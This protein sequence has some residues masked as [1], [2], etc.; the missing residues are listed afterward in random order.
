MLI[1]I[2]QGTTGTTCLALSDDL[3]PLARAYR[4]LPNRFP[5][6]G[7][8]EQEPE[9][10]LAT[11]VE[12][13]AEVLQV[14]GGEE[15]RAAGL[16]NQGETVVAWDRSTGEALGPAIVW[17]DRRSSTVVDALERAGKGQ[18]ISELSGL[19]LDAYFS[20]SKLSWLLRH[21]RRVQAAREAGSL[22]LG[23]LDAW[24]GWR[25]AGRTH[26][27]DHSTASRTQLLG[28]GG[29]DWDDELLDHFGVPREALPSVRTSLGARGELEHPSWGRPL[30]WTASLV[31]QPAALAGNACFAEGETKVTY[32]TGCFALANA[33]G[34]P[35]TPPAGL[36]PITAWSE[37]DDRVYAVEGGAFTAGTAINWLIQVGLL[38]APGETAD[39]A[40]SV[41]DAGDV[42]FLPALSGLGAPWWQQEAAGAFAG[43]SSG[44]TRAHL[45]RAV[46]DSIALRVRDILEAA[47][48]AGIRKPVA[49]LRVDGGLTSNRYL[50][51]RQADLLGL[52]LL[53][54]PNRE[55][56]AL[57]AAAMAGIAAGLFGRDEVREA[58]AAPVRIE[59]RSSARER[60]AEYYEWLDW[61]ERAC[62]LTE[63]TARVEER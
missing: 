39:L 43:L 50:M 2:D 11:V 60:D 29:D 18:A 54:S 5:R 15:V 25:L 38:A 33:G 32:G 3:T 26:L 19:R 30:P 4:D 45:V 48:S 62:Q 51:Q 31:D 12:T 63:R 58:V 36:L 34:T 20:A 53:L 57:G 17:S 40:E 59:P 49:G 27:T 28:P 44:T 13:V 9:E 46:L 24:I 10:I 21:D 22:L 7:W 52:P 55:A 23:T 42:R 1:G 47:W 37:A 41:E 61:V 16:A 6:P 14:A 8:V 35:P 56:T